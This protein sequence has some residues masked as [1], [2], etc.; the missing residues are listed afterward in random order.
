MPAGFPLLSGQS[1]LHTYGLMK[2]SDK[3]AKVMNLLPRKTHI[4]TGTQNLR[5]IPGAPGLLAEIPSP[6]G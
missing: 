5:G 2:P 4:L 3:I 6:W 1:F